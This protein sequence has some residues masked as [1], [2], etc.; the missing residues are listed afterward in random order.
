MARVLIGNFKGPKGDT[1]EKGPKG[2]TGP[3]GPKGATGAVDASTKIAYTTPTT[4]SAPAS[5]DT[6]ATLFGK[7]TK[8]LADLFTAVGK[9]LDTSKVVNNLTT[10]AE[11]YALDA[12]QGKVLNDAV[13]ELNSKFEKSVVLND[14]SWPTLLALSAGSY[15]INQGASG[16]PAPTQYGALILFKVTGARLVAIAT[17][18]DYSVYIFVGTTAGRKWVMVS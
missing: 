12:R 17:M 9:K 5:G 4:Y 11:G 6:I 15:V 16:S 13:G 3:Q 18:D 2:D 8:G 10:T 7:I 1:G 14:V